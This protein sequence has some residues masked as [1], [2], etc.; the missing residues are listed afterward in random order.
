LRRVRPQLLAAMGD[1]PMKYI[2]V[3]CRL[4]CGQKEGPRERPF[5]LDASVV[6]Y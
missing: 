4:Q 5:E 6:N 1:N 2:E 3:A